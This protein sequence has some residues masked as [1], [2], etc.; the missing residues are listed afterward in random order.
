M[1]KVIKYLVVFIILAGLVAATNFEYRYNPYTGRQDRSISLNQTGN[2]I[3][4]DYFLGDGSELTGIQQGALILYFLYQASDDVTGNLTLSSVKNTTEVTLTGTSLPAG[5][6]LFSDWITPAG[7]P[8]LGIIEAGNW[9]IHVEGKKTGGTK[10]VQFYYAIYI[11]NSTGGN[12]TLLA[13]ST[14]SDT[15]SAT[16]THY[17]VDSAISETSVSLTDRIR[18]KGYAYVSG[19]GSA[20]SVEAYI[21]GDSNT[22]MTLPVGAISI[23]RFVPYT[24][25]VNDVNLGSHDLIVGGDVGIGTTTPSQ[26][27]SV[28]GTLNVTSWTY[29]AGEYKCDNGTHTI[30]SRNKTLL[31][32]MGCTI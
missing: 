24:G 22:R 16:R 6:T 1:E 31:N 19:G 2:N 32:N 30:R 26:T 10:Q 4:A 23:E 12:E 3:T 20:P 15:V 21:Q 9:F 25:A 28:V 18:V 17:D 27:L 7:V 13:T 8:S 5:S 29:T 14:Y 11:T